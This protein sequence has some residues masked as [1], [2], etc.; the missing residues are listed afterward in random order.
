M[1]CVLV[2]ICDPSAP[3]LDSKVVARA[4]HALPCPSAVRWLND[5]V[6]CDL[7]FDRPDGVE[8]VDLENAVRTALEPAAVDVAILPSAG[9]RKA[10]LLADMDSTIIGQ[11]CIDELGALSGLGDQIADIT[12][13]AMRGDLDFSDA[14]R[15]RVSLM[16]GI[17]AAAID[18]VIAER[19]TFTPGGHL[20]V[21][22]MQANGGYAALV[23]GGFSAFTAFVAHQTGFDEHR[24]NHL[25]I[26][27]GLLTGAVAEPILGR[28]AKLE[29]LRELSATRSVPTSEIVA[30]GDGANDLDMLG[31]A[32]LGVAFHAKPIVSE[33]ARVRIDHGD[34][35][36]LLYLQGYKASEFM[37]Q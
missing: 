11:E 20:L 6:A 32:G 34:L 24:G 17:D 18:R 28:T 29:A 30:V 5:G 1:E 31:A 7:V 33:A 25:I 8:T 27:D 10:L 35:T 19:I 16:K 36:A 13:R 15:E 2:L 14:L 3:A 21:R 22:T 23:S 26:A 12:T 9:R 37:R 4:Q